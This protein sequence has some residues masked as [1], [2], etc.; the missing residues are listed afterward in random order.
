[1]KDQLKFQ[2]TILLSEDNCRNTR[3]EDGV[4]YSLVKAGGIANRKKKKKKKKTW[5]IGRSSV[6]GLPRSVVNQELPK[7]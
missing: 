2:G 6:L 3:K 1:M 4:I 7:K 5:K